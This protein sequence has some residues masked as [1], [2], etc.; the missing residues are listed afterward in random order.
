VI[1][2]QLRLPSFELFNPSKS[3]ANLHALHAHSMT[4]ANDMFHAVFDLVVG[5]LA[6]NETLLSKCAGSDLHRLQSMRI[7]TRAVHM[8]RFNILDRAICLARDCFQPHLG[9]PV[10]AETGAKTDSCFLRR[11][12][13]SVRTAVWINVSA[14]SKWLD[15]EARISAQLH[16]AY[17][18]DVL[19]AFEYKGTTSWQAHALNSSA[20]AWASMLGEWGVATDWE[21]V[22]S[23]L[24]ANPLHLS[25][26]SRASLHSFHDGHSRWHR[27]TNS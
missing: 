24:I 17:D 13:A 26:N 3:A 27:P 12:N 18:Y 20:R 10:N 15:T 23:F 14:L 2:H 22:R 25:R 19:S 21:R 16:M 6:P 9:F 1:N 11:T 7:G 5:K 4:R 8:R